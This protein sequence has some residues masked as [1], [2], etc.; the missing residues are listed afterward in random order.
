[1]S[2]FFLLCCLLV[3]C[4]VVSGKSSIVNNH[5]DQEQIINKINSNPASTWVAGINDRFTYMT[6]AQI[7]RQMGALTPPPEIANLLPVKTSEPRMVGVIPP[8]FDARSF[9]PRCPS[10]AMIR[11]QSSCGSCWAFGAVE[12]ATDR[13]CIE[14]NATSQLMISAN[15]LTACCA[16]CGFGCGGGYLPS[17]WDYLTSTGIVT[18]GNYNDST[19]LQWCQKYSL[20]NCAHHEPGMYPSCPTT[21]Y[22]TP[23]CMSTCDK[24]THYQMTYAADHRKFSKS[25][26]LPNDVNAIA[27]EILMHGPV[28]AAFTVYED[29]LTYK[30][31]VYV[32][33]SQQAVGGH[34]VKLMGWGTENGADYWLVANSWNEGWGDHGTFKIARGTDECGIESQVVAGVYL[35]QNA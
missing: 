21:E 6:A 8:T 25:Y 29:F 9:W 24:G 31:G 1:M 15:D 17:A 28:E 10:I 34:A 22:D 33:Q 7:K 23:K 13:I 32:H 27:T 26:S 14:T 16:S 12:A 18:G 35:A 4:V 30:S 20:P 3:F 11:D 2:R 5:L 19:T